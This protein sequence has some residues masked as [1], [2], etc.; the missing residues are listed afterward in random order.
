MDVVYTATVTD[1]SAD[2]VDLQPGVTAKGTPV[3]H[4]INPWR[5]VREC[6]ADFSIRF[7]F[8]VGDVVTVLIKGNDVRIDPEPESRFN[9]T[10]V[11]A[12][13]DD[14]PP[15]S[16]VGPGAA[17]VGGW[18]GAHNLTVVDDRGRPLRYVRGSVTPSSIVPCPDGRTVLVVGAKNGQR[19][20]TGGIAIEVVDI[21]KGEVVR[22]PD[23]SELK[24]DGESEIWPW[25]VGCIDP[26]G[27]SIVVWAPRDPEA[28]GEHGD[29]A[30]RTRRR[31]DGTLIVSGGHDAT[32][33]ASLA[34]LAVVSGTP[35]PHLTLVDGH[36]GAVTVSRD[37]PEA[38]PVAFLGTAATYSEVPLIAFSVQAIRA[39]SA[40]PDGTAATRSWS[41]VYVDLTDTADPK[42]ASIP[43]L[44]YSSQISMNP[45]GSVVI[46]G[47]N[48]PSV[49]SPFPIRSDSSP[50]EQTWG[51]ARNLAALPAGT[52]MIEQPGNYDEPPGYRP[53]QAWWIPRDGSP[54]EGRL[55]GVHAVSVLALP[56]ASGTR[57]G[58]PDRFWTDDALQAARSKSGPGIKWETDIEERAARIARGEEKPWIA[59][60]AS[61]ALGAAIIRAGI[62]VARRRPRTDRASP[63][64]SAGPDP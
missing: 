16:G 3:G 59:V 53:N 38:G 18:V 34:S 26:T 32:W 24:G 50:G 29:A 36:S 33:N 37:L 52:L 10:I 7:K 44:P 56:Q 41:V 46:M 27:S 30:V 57:F 31:S 20:D 21:E 62:V 49:A 40:T 14:L 1:V 11:K 8:S 17:V 43:G 61:A 48:G 35:T 5:P 51:W 60:V 63:E 19:L 47:S 13:L 15:P 39:T 25:S 4:L 28:Q 22:R 54:I 6:M 12:F 45:N 55:P 64:D 58:S 9:E 23:L 2:T 42:A